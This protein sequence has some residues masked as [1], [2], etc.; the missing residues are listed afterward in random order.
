MNI[1]RLKDREYKHDQTLLKVF[2]DG[3]SKKIKLVRMNYLKT[4]EL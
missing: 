4:M 1:Q 3:E 2:G